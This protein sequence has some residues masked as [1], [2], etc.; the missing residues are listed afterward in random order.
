MTNDPTTNEPLPGEAVADGPATGEPAPG[1]PQPEPAG[2]EDLRRLGEGRFLSLTTYRRD[3]T[4]VAT[5]VWTVADGQRLLV[6]TNGTTAKVK[7]LRH[8]DRVLLA[9]CDARGNVQG[10]SVLGTARVLPDSELAL[11][12]RS[13]KA[14][15]RVGF[16]LMRAAVRAR[17]LVGRTT[18]APH[19]GIEITVGPSAAGPSPTAGA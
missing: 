13:M 6:W 16:P 8:T 1:P 4:P 18:S 14:K 3:G 5:P 11:V 19:V 9:G 7:R 2:A 12:E 15:Y 10:A 17:G